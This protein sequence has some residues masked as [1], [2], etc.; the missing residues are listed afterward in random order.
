MGDSDCLKLGVGIS[1]DAK[2]LREDFGAPVRG[3]FDIRHLAAD[4]RPEARKLGMAGLASSFL[5]LRLDKDWRVR[6]S[7]WE[8]DDLSQRQTLYAA[9]DALV[10]INIAMQAAYEDVAS[11]QSWLLHS[12]APQSVEDLGRAA[13]RLCRDKRG[14]HFKAKSNSK[15][16]KE[17]TDK[18]AKEATENTRYSRA[19]C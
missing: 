17:K 8:A 1:D 11:R 13:I 4:H 3:W 14:I 16:A 7:D 19:P 10:S 18:K 5:G 2:K 6:A 9:N 12:G 15:G